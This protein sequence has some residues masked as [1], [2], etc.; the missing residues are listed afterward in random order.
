[1]EV[2]LSV[3]V[4]R[5]WI[6]VSGHEYSSTFAAQKI[7]DRSRCW[8]KR[9][10]GLLS[11]I[12]SR[13]IGLLARKPAKCFNSPRFPELLYQKKI[14]SASCFVLMWNAWPCF[15]TRSWIRLWVCTLAFRKSVWPQWYCS[16]ILGMLGVAAILL[17]R[18]KWPH[19]GRSSSVSLQPASPTDILHMELMMIT[20]S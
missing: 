18:Q 2:R 17:V 13:Y 10:S 5:R 15:G 1:M 3:F 6:E 11:G 16:T 12:E 4:I 19:P 8:E 20:W 9:I 7:E 14:T